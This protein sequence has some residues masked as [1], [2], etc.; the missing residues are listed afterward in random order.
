M[1][2]PSR[3]GNFT[4]G[5]V[6]ALLEP[7]ANGAHAAYVDFV[8]RRTHAGARSERVGGKLLERGSLEVGGACGPR[9][10]IEGLLQSAVGRVLFPNLYR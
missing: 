3:L 4:C 1:M 7:A 9:G 6:F 5:S 2:N 8:R 10:L